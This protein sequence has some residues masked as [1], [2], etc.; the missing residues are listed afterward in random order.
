MQEKN[1]QLDF[2]NQKIFIGLDV[3]KKKWV[4]TIRMNNMELK[5]YSMEPSVERLAKYLRRN[6]PKAKYYSVYEAGFSGYWADRE[7]R[8]NGIENIIVNPADVPTT[9]KEKEKKDDHKDSRKLA[10]ELEN[11]TIQ[12]IYIPPIEL[13]ELRSLSRLRSQFVE[14]RARIKNRIKGFLLYYGKEFPGKNTRYW[15]DSLLSKLRAI[16]FSTS[17]AEETMSNYLEHLVLLQERVKTVEQLLRTTA[18]ELNVMR[19]IKKIESI[20]GIGFVSAIVIYSE[21]F[22]IK[23]FKKLDQLCS[24]IGLVPSTHSSGEKERTNGLTLRQKSYLKNIIIEASWIAV[25]RDPALTM[26]YSKFIQRMDSQKA[27]IKI[28]KK[29]LNR[30]RYVWLNE[31]EYQLA[32]VK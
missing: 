11:H 22:D 28:S 31:K 4:V 15:S 20:P 14:E 19:T 16:K 18:E 30:I 17:I 6:Y 3:H 12:G 13:E 25:R 23:R 26:S 21:L 27:I 7:L 1:N 29:L 10:R 8:K 24:Y 2:S 9:N 5:T 32:I